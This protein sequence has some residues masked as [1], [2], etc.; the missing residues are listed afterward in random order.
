MK[1]FK[2]EEDKKHFCTNYYLFGKK[3]Y[4]KKHHWQLYVQYRKYQDAAKMAYKLLCFCDI[5]SCKKAS[6]QLRERQKKMSEIL[7]LFDVFARKNSIT[8]WIDFGTLLGA[9]RHKGFI[10]W[11]Y[12]VDICMLRSDLYKNLDLIKDFFE[13]NA[14]LSFSD[15][16]HKYNHYI[17]F[18]CPEKMLGIDIF[19]LDT[20]TSSKSSEFITN[21]IRKARQVLKSWENNSNLTVSNY[22]E[23]IPDIV[24]EVI[25]KPVE[26]KN[27]EDLLYYSPDYGHPMT[28][29]VLKKEDV[30]PLVDIEFESYKFLAPKNYKKILIQCY[31]DIDDFPPLFLEYEGTNDCRYGELEYPS[32]INNIYSTDINTKTWSSKL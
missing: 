7:H 21:K 24:N 29:L 32:G 23:V 8:Y 10:P 14:E 6:G 15:Y 20:V 5:K 27:G 4:I 9:Y 13:K 22:K 25:N 1:L 3:I 17:S 18:E 31:G 30:F 16:P 19:P 12:D 11:D 26:D 28:N 2:I